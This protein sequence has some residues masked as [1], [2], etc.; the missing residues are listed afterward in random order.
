M[1]CLQSLLRQTVAFEQI[2]LVDN[3]SSIPV[4]RRIDRELLEH[5]TLLRLDR[6]E[7]FT[8]GVNRAIRDVRCELVALVNNDVL[9]QEDWLLHV[10]AAFDDASVAAAQAILV[11]E[12]GVVDGAGI[13][14]IE[15]RVRQLG[16]GSTPDEVD[17]SRFWGVSA[18]AALYRVS[19]LKAI[20]RERDFLH[21]AFFAYYEDVDLAAR[22][23]ANH[24]QM[25]LVPL[26]LGVHQGSASAPI[27]GRRALLLRVRNRYWVDRLHPSLLNRSSLLKEDFRRIASAVARLQWLDA[28]TI[29]RGI[30]AGLF[31]PLT[32]GASS[33]QLLS[34][35]H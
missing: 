8:G 35:D 26:V 2:I 17:V 16:R 13:E 30:V 5:V 7:G 23:A 22:I 21:A 27:L 3:G 4:E 14:L 19:S 24:G 29:L 18:T 20:S 9:L 11:D 12:K 31:G 33:R 32:G 25:K 10:I 6:N 34:S 15:G 28:A 1:L